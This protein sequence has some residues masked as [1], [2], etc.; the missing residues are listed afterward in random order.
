[1]NIRKSLLITFAST[2]ANLSLEFIASIIMARLLTPSEFGVFSIAMVLIFLADQLRNFGVGG[3]VVQEKEL[4][5]ERINSATGFNFLVSWIMA[6]VIWLVA[7][8]AA[9]FYG[10]HGVAQVMWVLALNFFLLPF[11]AI[12]MSLMRREML[13]DRIAKIQV[14]SSLTRT[15]GSVVLAYM[16]LSYLSMAWAS[17][18]ATIMTIFMVQFLK[19]RHIKQRT[20]F[21]DIRRILRFGSLATLSSLV[22]EGGRRLPDLL[23]GRLISIEAVAFFSRASGLI[24]L[25]HRLILSVVWTV[26]M[27]HFA[28][29]V[30][31][32][33]PLGPSYLLATSHITALAWPFLVVLA[34]AAPQLIPILYGK[35]W[36]A[37][38][39]LVQILCLSEFLI[40]PFYL[41]D[42]ALVAQGRVDMD[43]WLTVST[44]VLRLPFMIFLAP[45]GLVSVAAGYS[46]ASLILVLI[47]YQTVRRVI[48]FTF[49]DFW[50]AL[51]PSL[52][53][54]IV[55]ALP[56]VAVLGLSMPPLMK[57][58]LNLLVAS[59]AWM[60]GIWFT[61]HPMRDE[62]MKLMDQAR[63]KLGKH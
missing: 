9:T 63:G 62:L 13:F 54:A 3:Y 16:G 10:N 40:A 33:T 61:R 7:T 60:L 30:R 45:Y 34:A 57:L 46:V 43:T 24:E 38:I 28:A 55:V 56:L 20:G 19:P 31:Q 42:Q 11:S 5:P 59:L 25:F 23:L 39:Q 58:A 48:H 27:P 52:F 21:T 22:N 32:K 49:R 15:V 47:Y 2:Y 14:A 26:S 35:Q 29:Q 41:Q 50:L 17:V 12:T 36:D 1:V 53:V 37:S 4:T 51:W 6:L 18:I 44:V 8:P